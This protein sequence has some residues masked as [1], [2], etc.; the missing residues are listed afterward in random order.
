[1]T[2]SRTWT[3]CLFSQMCLIFCSENDK[4]KL[5]FAQTARI[6]VYKSHKALSL[7]WQWTQGQN[8]LLHIL[9]LTDVF[10]WWASPVSHQFLFYSPD[11]QKRVCSALISPLTWKVHIF[12]IATVRLFVQLFKLFCFS[13]IL[14]IDLS[15]RLLYLLS[16][17]LF[18]LELYVCTLRAAE[19]HNQIPYVCKLIWCLILIHDKTQGLVY[20]F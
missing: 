20:A 8:R 16:L 5:I 6:F 4:C 1:M 11:G 18:V 2:S 9:D 7:C 15:C 14:P 19:K 12:H 3:A 10:A 13:P 17:S